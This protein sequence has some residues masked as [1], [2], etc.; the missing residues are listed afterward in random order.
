MPGGI[1]ARSR[2]FITT[3]KGVGVTSDFALQLLGNSLWTALLLAGP[4]LLL[5]LVV[6][7]AVSV[8]QAVTQIQE[9][10]LTFIPKMLAM[11]GAFLILGPWMMRRLVEF[12]TVLISNIPYYF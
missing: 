11:F 3:Y 12:A 1:A 9:M 4:I 5:T 6:G 7:L 8:L 10:S 2:V